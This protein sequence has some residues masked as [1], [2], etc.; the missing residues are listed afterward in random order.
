MKIRTIVTTI[1]TV[2]LTAGFVAP[3]SAQD[4]GV[5]PSDVEVI[6]ITAKRPQPTVAMTCFNEVR[7]QAVA[8][9]LQ[10]DDNSVDEKSADARR[11]LRSAV[12]QCIDQA[13]AQSD[14]RI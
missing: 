10:H 1:A 9:R 14:T 8:N 12:R 3:S 6:T 5:A 7:A 2:L 13:T 4:S 11:D